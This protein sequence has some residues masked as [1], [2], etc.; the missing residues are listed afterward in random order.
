[1][2]GALASADDDRSAMLADMARLSPTPIALPSLLALLGYQAEPIG[3]GCFALGSMPEIVLLFPFYRE[4]RLAVRQQRL[5]GNNVLRSAAI[6]AGLAAL[7]SGPAR[8]SLLFLEHPA[9][10][11]PSIGRQNVVSLQGGVVPRIWRNCFGRLDMMARFVG[12]PPHPGQAN[13]AI[14]AIEVAI[15][16]VQAIM[17]LKLEL[18]TRALNR[19][20][21]PDSPLRPRLTISAAHGGHSGLVLP[22]V[23]DLVISRRYDPA[24]DVA[25]AREEVE[26]TVRASLGAKLAADFTVI[27]HQHPLPDPAA[28]RRTREERALAAGWGWPQVPFCSSETL[29]PGCI[30]FGGLERPGIDPDGDAASTTLDDMAGLSRSLRA[31]LAPV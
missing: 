6:A 19:V 18:E 1:M 29:V 12:R 7:R 31:L 25:V 13:A 9:D 15:P 11:P 16:A 27:D 8:P 4:S 26:E 21:V 3:T 22:S 17:R 20:Q 23:F 24:E 10:L 28:E 30:L 2:S 5:V 14:N